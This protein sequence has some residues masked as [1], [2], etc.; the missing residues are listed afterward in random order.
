MATR[1]EILCINRSD[2]FNPYERIINVGGVNA[3]G[4]RWKLSQTEA[5][6]LIV[7]DTCLFYVNRGGNQVNVV[8]ATS[9]YGYKYLKTTTDGEQPDN[10]LSLPECPS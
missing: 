1:F 8:I 3:Q 10:L 9:Q 5:I 7:K 4:T 6:H 2:R